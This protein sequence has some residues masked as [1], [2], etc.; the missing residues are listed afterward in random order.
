MCSLFTLFNILMNKKTRHIGK[1]KAG[2]SAKKH[3][4]KLHPSEYENSCFIVLYFKE[5]TI[6]SKKLQ[7]TVPSLTSRERTV[8]TTPSKNKISRKRKGKG[9]R[10]RESENG[11]EKEKEKEKKEEKGKEENKKEEKM[12]RA[13]LKFFFEYTAPSKC[14]P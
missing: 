9:K 7:S 12:E 3:L 8:Q 14:I 10:R 6:D 5:G 11:R 4:R 13:V 2:S 1:R